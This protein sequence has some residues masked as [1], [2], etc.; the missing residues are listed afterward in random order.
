M[1]L[2]RTEEFYHLMQSRRS[3]RKF[4]SRP[5]DEA[6]IELAVKTAGLAPSGANKQPWF[7][8][9]IKSL[10]VKQRMRDE[11]ERVERDFYE[12]TAGDEWLKDLAPFKTTPN[13]NFLTEAP[14]VIAVFA[15]IS[16][17]EL[18]GA[19]RTYY[20]MESTGI[21]VGMLLTALH[22]AGLA[23]LTHTPRPMGFLNEL[24]GLERCYRPYMLIVTGYA[25]EDCYYPD[26]QRK[27]WDE[28]ARVY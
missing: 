16:R 3:V 5:V 24:L 8:G 12:R 11:A 17:P 20:P 6:V 7:F 18:E 13:K 22:N 27:N 25:A 28:V 23:T 10:E 15:K 26:I 21:A 19:E 4:S 9:I 2:E 1:S 14:V